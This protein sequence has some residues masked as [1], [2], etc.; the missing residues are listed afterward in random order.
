MELSDGWRVGWR[1]VAS[2]CSG[3][4]ARGAQACRLSVLAAL[5]ESRSIKP[6]KKGTTNRSARRGSI[7]RTPGTAASA[8]SFARSGTSA[9]C[10]A[11][12]YQR[13]RSCLYPVAGF[14]GG[15]GV[16][17]PRTKSQIFP[18][19]GLHRYRARCDPRLASHVFSER[20]SLG[21]C[22]AKSF[23]CRLAGTP[24]YT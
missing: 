4:R 9:A 20:I 8:R 10:F 11:V 24:V 22:S 17:G 21:S 15:A 23:A 5:G 7:V 18:E 2:N 6:P 13:T 3:E 12:V 14:A 1:N 19:R 16:H